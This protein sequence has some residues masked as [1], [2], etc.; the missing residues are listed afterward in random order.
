MGNGRQLSPGLS[1]VFLLDRSRSGQFHRMRKF[2]LLVSRYGVPQFQ[3]LGADLP[4]TLIAQVTQFHNQ[5]A[6][7]PCVH[8]AGMNRRKRAAKHPVASPRFG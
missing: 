7:T 4:N 2:A 8:S 6:R 1:F 3:V 5:R